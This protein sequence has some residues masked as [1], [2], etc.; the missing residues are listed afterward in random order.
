MSDGDIA[1]HPQKGACWSSRTCHPVVNIV[2]VGPT[3]TKTLTFPTKTMP[4][5]EEHQY[6]QFREAGDNIIEEVCVR[7]A[8]TSTSNGDSSFYVSLQDIRDVFPDALIEPPRIAFYPNKILDVITRK[9]Q[10]NNSNNNS[11]NNSDTVIHLPIS[12]KSLNPVSQDSNLSLSDSAQSSNSSLTIRNNEI[13]L[14]QIKE[15]LLEV[16]GRGDE[17]LKSQL[18]AKEKDEMIISLQQQALDRLAT[19]QKYADAILVQNFELHEYP[20]PRLFIILPVDSTKWDPMNVLGNKFRLHFLS[21]MPLATSLTPIPNLD[22]ALNHSIN[23]MEMLSK[24]YPI[25]DNM[26]KIDD[27][28]ALEG[29]DLR[30]LGTFLRINDE[31][32]KLGNLYRITTETGHVKWVCFEHYRS[33]YREKEQKAFENAVVMNGGKYDSYLGRA[34]ITLRSRTRAGEFFNALANARRIYE[35]DILFSWDWSKTDLEAFVNA[36]MTSS[37]SILRLELGRFREASW[38]LLSTS[39]RYEALV[40]IIELSKIRSIHIVLPPNLMKIPS[41]QHKRSSDLHKLTIEMKPQRI[42]ASNFQLLVNLLKTDTVLTT[43]SLK[44]NS[45]GNEGALALSE[46]LRTNMALSTLNLEHN[47]ISKEGALAL[48]EALGANKTLTTLNLRGNL[49][50]KE[51]ILALSKA[52]DTNT[53]L[54]TLDLDCK[55][56]GDKAIVALSKA[57]KANTTLTTL[58]LRY[59][60]IGGLAVKALSEA[61]KTNTALTTLILDFNSI[62]YG[63]ILYLSEALKINTTLATLNLEIN[64]IDKEGALAL[65]EALEDNVG[66]TILS[67]ESNSIGVEGAL[68]LSKALKTNTTLTA[69]KLQCSLMCKK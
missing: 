58:N 69:L 67:L 52:L 46:A 51:G 60:S 47:S 36:L 27:Y 57:L 13:S 29:A 14:D 55:I 43:L 53:T 42:G 24:E 7:T 2:R 40:R 8:S 48:S 12:R 63:G 20:I 17:M 10:L 41:L 33:T 34:I 30:R 25:L 59:S 64:R 9:P 56:I 16:K 3:C 45:V 61:L 37:V 31:D 6:Q 1:A 5:A 32:R 39:S 62:L 19:L 65:S 22:A 11:N 44:G 49:I 66:L 21:G 15:L 68:A 23:Y 54:S 26:N 4:S 50:G 28:E 38:K 18:E 35:L